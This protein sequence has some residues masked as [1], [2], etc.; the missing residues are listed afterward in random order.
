MHPD[1]VQAVRAKSRW[2]TFQTEIPDQYLEVFRFR[3][4]R[5]SKPPTSRRPLQWWLWSYQS[6]VVVGSTVVVEPGVV[7]V[8]GATVV[9]GAK[10]VDVEDVESVTDV[11][12]EAATVVLV[13]LVEVVVEVPSHTNSIGIARSDESQWQT[14]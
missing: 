8:V 12:V 7:L 5:W 3:H 10:V 14:T 1:S 11:V 6:N 2:T 4:Q 13:V 9:V